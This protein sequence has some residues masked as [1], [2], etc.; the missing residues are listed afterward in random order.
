[1]ARPIE[2]LILSSRSRRKI[3]G[4]DSN[5]LKHCQSVGMASSTHVGPWLMLPLIHF[6]LLGYLPVE[7]MRNTTDPS[8]AAGCG[9][10][11][12]VRNCDYFASGGHAKIKTTMHD[13]L[14]LPRLFR[15]YGYRTDLA[16]LTDLA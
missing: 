11:I 5:A 1:M 13:G 9:Q 4:S 15:Q 14:L 16:D 8:F 12:L 3:C 2:R 7:R 6:V 10:F